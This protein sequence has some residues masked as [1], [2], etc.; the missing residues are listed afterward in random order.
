MAKATIELLEVKPQ[1]DNYI[2]FS[3]DSTVR[4]KT[5]TVG[6]WYYKHADGQWRIGPENPIP[7]N[8]LYRWHSD[9]TAAFKDA[10]LNGLDDVCLPWIKNNQAA[11]LDAEIDRF[12]GKHSHC[13]V[14]I[15]QKKTEIEELEKQEKEFALKVAELYKQRDELAA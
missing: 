8:V 10:T 7:G 5:L 13:G 9:A 4:G 2:Y 14:Q 12:V 6:T 1:G 11:I 3:L 15:T